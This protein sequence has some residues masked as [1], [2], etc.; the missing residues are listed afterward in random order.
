[1]RSLRRQHPAADRRAYRPAAGFTIVETLIVLAIA[2]FI[3]LIV[4]QAIPTLLRNS[5]NNQ[6]RQDVQTIL[7]AVS[8][9]ELNNSGNFPS[10]CGPSQPA[11]CTQ[12]GGG[13]NPNDYFLQYD[14]RNLS[15][16][17][18]IDITSMPQTTAAGGRMDRAPITNP[19]TLQ[20][21][22][23]EK[24]SS[25]TPGG[26]TITGASYSDVVALYAIES[27]NSGGLSSECQQL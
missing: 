2:G 8:H 17:Q 13:P 21:Y 11:L 19:E 4:F 3:L 10:V 25:T 15:F 6:R 14:R 27:N 16:Y 23:Y 22:N 20:L 24:C 5:R 26:A 18:P 12:S 1:M 9:Y 7:S